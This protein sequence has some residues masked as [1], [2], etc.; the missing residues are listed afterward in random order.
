MTRFLIACLPL[1]LP[2]AA[3]AGERTVMVTGFDTIR[4][5]GP[6]VVTAT[7]GG[8][9][10]AKITGDA[11]ALDMVDIEMQGRTLIISESA[12]DWGGYPGQRHE[13]PTIAV[14]AHDIGEVA[15]RGG[16]A[17]TLD[18]AEAMHVQL[19]VIGSGSVS[20]GDV[21]ADTLD[22]VVAGSGSLTVSGRAANANFANS[23]SGSIDAAG[24]NVRDLNATSDG[25]GSNRFTAE[26]TADITA[27]GVGDVTVKGPAACKIRGPGPV[28]CEKI[29]D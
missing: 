20:V 4:V 9:P 18:R 8:P 12:S 21:R 7:T 10:G 27:L 11:R 17:I 22:A 26:R 5:D 25:T 13:R 3:H 28:R 14:S 24:L 16:G 19:G 23:G 1:L 2:L 6:F 29:A 15:V